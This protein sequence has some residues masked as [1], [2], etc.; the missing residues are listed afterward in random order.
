[1]NII[2]FL[3]VSMAATVAVIASTALLLRLVPTAVELMVTLRE[4]DKKITSLEEKIKEK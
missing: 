4:M 2:L 3:L 1:M